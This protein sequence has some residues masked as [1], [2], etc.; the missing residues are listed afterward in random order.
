[1]IILHCLY[2][3]EKPDA[4]ILFGE[5]YSVKRPLPGVKKKEKT[6]Y[7]HVY[8]VTGEEIQRVLTPFSNLPVSASK[9]YTLKLPGITLPFKSFDHITCDIS[10]NQHP[11]SF[12]FYE[13]PLSFTQTSLLVDILTKEEQVSSFV[14]SGSLRYWMAVTLLACELVSRGRYLP[15][16]GPN[17]SGGTRA[18]WRAVPASD[19]KRRIEILLRSMPD[20]QT[21]FI[22]NGLESPVQMSHESILNLFM[23]SIITQVITRA[24]ALRQDLDHFSEET[25]FHS[26]QECICLKT[27]TGSIQKELPGKNA[28]LKA[29]WGMQLSAWAELPDHCIPDDPQYHIC[30]R[31][32]GPSE[33]M[34]YLVPYLRPI[35]DPDTLITD[36]DIQNSQVIEELSIPESLDPRGD[37]KKALTEVCSAFSEPASPVSSPFGMGL[38]IPESN[39]LN[40]LSEEIPRIRTLRYELILPE[41]WIGPRIIPKIQMIVNR[42]EG[43]NTSFGLDSLLSFDYRIIIDDISLN[44]QEFFS[45]AHQTAG[46]IQIHG[47]IVAYD[48]EILQSLL[49][50]AKKTAKHGFT[51]RSYIRLLDEEEENIV[52]TPGDEWTEKIQQ[53]I[54]E[55]IKNEIFPQIPGFT[56]MLRP[57]QVKGYSFLIGSRNIGFSVCLADDMGLGKTIQAIAYILSSLQEDREEPALIVCPTSIIG[58]WERE[59]AKFAP[60]LVVRAHH[61]PNREKG[62]SFLASRKNADIFITTYAL[63]HRDNAFLRQITWS[64]LILD[65]AHHI[66]NPGSAQFQAMKLIRSVHQVALTGTPVGNSL[67]ELWAI[68]DQLC[69]GLLHSLPFFQKNYITPIEQDKNQEKKSE[70]T[71]LIRPFLLR[72]LKT[73]PAIISDLPSKMEIREYYTLTSEQI[74]AYQTVIDDLSGNLQ[75]VSGFERRGAILAALIRLKQICNHPVLPY[76]GDITNIQGSGKII[77]LLEMLEEIREEG[78]AAVLFTQYATF[79]EGLVNIISSAFSEEVLLL[80]GKT[81]RLK[82]EENIMRFSDPDGPRFFVISLRAGGTGL[83]L[84][85]AVHVFHIDRW[86]NPAVEDQATDRAFRI[87]QTR[88]VQVHL[89]I[90]SGTLEEKIDN[91]LAEKQSLAREIIPTGEEW[92]ADMNNSDLIEVLR[93]HASIGEDEF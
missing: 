4:L 20:I 68:M 31:L 61:G 91:M 92:L 54:R 93:L 89:M 85:R 3:P 74:R 44:E 6:P 60:G 84:M 1:M 46:V 47:R 27:L 81:P 25:L 62:V 23:N 77:R 75:D 39:I 28:R 7:P 48:R 76:G 52:I 69:P 37:M 8:A 15:A 64:S 13:V 41:W 19:D 55:G 59:L 21:L 57:Y 32:D 90:G 17:P 78:D 42:N 88:N 14:I 36:N 49:Q 87:G 38:A 58:N 10:Y 18:I 51:V 22:E 33:G 45:Y 83:N 66:K 53:F 9:T 34:Y 86:W 71:R 50:K 16:T 65:E 79:A 80:T 70:L 82:R 5:D 40:F 30:L 73:D 26:L 24:C 29:Q 2:T 11:D 12:R 35:D 67:V 72:R 63:V 43:C 56:G